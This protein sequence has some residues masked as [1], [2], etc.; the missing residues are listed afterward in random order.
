[1]NAPCWRMMVGLLVLFSSAAMAQPENGPPRW[2]T[3]GPRL[4]EGPA[5]FEVPLQVIATKL[6]ADVEIG[7]Q[8]VRFVV[9]TGSPSMIDSALVD[10]LGLPVVGESQGTD[11]HGTVIRSRIV[12][13]DIR[14]GGVGFTR[15]PMFVAPFADNAATRAIVGDGVL[16]SEL[17]A[18]GG[19]QFDLRS[20]VL[21]FDAQAENLPHVDTSRKTPLHDFGYPHA[22][23]FD[24]RFAEQARSKAMLD[25]GSPGYF[26]IS[27]PDLEGAAKAGG[28]GREIQ[29]YG[30]PG[31][32]LGG[33][34]PD[35][36]QWMGE[37]PTFSLAGLAPARVEAI[38]R[39]RSPSLL[40]ARWLE[41]FIITLDATGGSAWFHEYAGKPFAHAAFGFTLAF[42]D[43]V[44]VAMVWEGSPAARAGLAPGLVLTAINGE[45]PALTEDGIHAALAAMQ[46]NEIALA[47]EGG[48]AVLG[49]RT[50]LLDSGILDSGQARD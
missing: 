45:A 11:A 10:A 6:Y 28:I 43:A 48:S 21:R 31:A 33:Q 50:S 32:S 49:Q 23:I 37:M 20:G 47:W 3:E 38:R 2:V 39:E 19:W 36:E 30:S 14:V 15:V 5:A 22:P 7:G 34:A 17:L 13:A 35:A 40:G 29:G 1:M 25:T 18:L 41:H 12:Q 24:V 9:D 44:S 8:T 46:A 27:P 42:D 26:A 16:G 4:A